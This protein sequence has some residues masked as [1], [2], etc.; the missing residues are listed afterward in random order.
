MK[1]K[2]TD[3]F[4]DFIKNVCRVHGN[5]KIALKLVERED[6]P[7]DLLMYFAQTRDFPLDVPIKISENRGAPAAVLDALIERFGP[8]GDSFSTRIRTAIA[9]NPNTSRETLIKLS[10]DAND[11][12]RRAALRRL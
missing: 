7:S 5:W 6:A 2:Q 9:K 4:F 1:D 10:K 11:V 12:I 8:H 3:P